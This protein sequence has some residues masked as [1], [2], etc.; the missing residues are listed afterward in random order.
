VNVTQLIDKIHEIRTHYNKNSGILYG[1]NERFDEVVE[2]INAI[3]MYLKDVS[4]VI[5]FSIDDEFV[6][7]QDKGIYRK[8]DVEPNKPYY[9]QEQSIS[10]GTAVTLFEEYDSPVPVGGYVLNIYGEKINAW[11]VAADEDK[12]YINNLKFDMVMEAKNE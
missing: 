3:L 7:I 5:S 12:Q 4:Q 9:A 6:Y 8:Q 11:G 1:F 2:E 10:I